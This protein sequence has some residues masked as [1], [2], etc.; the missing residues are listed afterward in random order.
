MIDNDIKT[1]SFV[2]YTNSVNYEEISFKGK[3]RYYVT[4]FISTNDID[5]EN[6][7]VTEK[8]MTEMLSELNSRSVTTDYDHDVF[9]TENN[10][11][12]AVGKIV[13]A[14]LKQK[15]SKV[16]IWAKVELNSSW[17]RFDETGKIVMNFSEL[18]SS[19]KGGF[20][21]AFSIAFKPLKSVTKIVDGVKV[22]M[23]D[24]LELLNVAI[25]GMPVN[26]G[27]V[28][29]GYN[30][31]SVLRNSMKEDVNESLEV[32]NNKLDVLNSRLGSIDNKSEEK[33]MSEEKA[34]EG[35]DVKEVVEDSAV[36]KKEEVEEKP[37][38][39][40]EAEVEEKG[41]EKEETEPKVDVE[42]KSKM[43]EVLK[44]L[45]SVTDRLKSLETKQKSGVFKSVVD[46]EAPTEEIKK[47]DIGIIASI[48]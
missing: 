42:Q 29:D 4:G 1:K 22:K 27:A 34:P 32:I 30:M 21:N 3:K 47:E 39:P 41:E 37:E 40:V 18:W 7:V 31:K 35:E 10:N 9:R 17:K 23:I 44:E 28:M 2:F 36:E 38:A 25:T 45:K 12:L 33:K 24:S 20:S 13:D 14:K 16:G 26:S 5:I 19:I 46:A 8:A 11:L 43:D 6:E 48:R 15:G